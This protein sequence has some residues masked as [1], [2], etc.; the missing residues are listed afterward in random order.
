MFTPSWVCNAQNNLVDN[1][2]FE[3]TSVFNVENG[4]S[5]IATTDKIEFPHK[6]N[7]TWQNMLMK[8][9]LKSLVEKHLM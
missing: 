7:K 2:W 3:K 5:W 9:D 8:E 6:K 1:A 4:K